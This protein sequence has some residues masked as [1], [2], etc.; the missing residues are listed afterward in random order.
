MLH[1]MKLATEPFNKIALGKKVIESRLYDAKRQSISL[2]DEI[3]F[4]DTGNPDRTVRVRV[5][6]LLR[7]PSFRALFAAHDPSLFGGTT[8]DAL[9]GEIKKFYSD[10]EEREQG[11]VGILIERID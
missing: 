4:S 9:L 3:E 1:A 2:G 11:V 6:Q 8:V 7:Y 5:K 10:A